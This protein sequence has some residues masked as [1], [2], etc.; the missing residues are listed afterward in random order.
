[1]DRRPTGEMAGA[2]PPHPR[3]GAP[4]SPQILRAAEERRRGRNGWPLA[5]ADRSAGI[6]EADRRAMQ[7]AIAEWSGRTERPRRRRS[8]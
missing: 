3:R 1:M 5:E 6:P 7:S 4:P 2:N 8:K